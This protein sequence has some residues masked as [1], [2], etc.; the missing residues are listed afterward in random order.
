M[1]NTWILGPCG[2]DTPELY[3]QTGLHL[4][5]LMEDKYWFYKASFDKANRSSFDSKRCIGLKEGLKVFEEIKRLYSNIRLTTDVHEC[6]QVEQLAPLI[7]CIQIPAFLCRQTDL[8]IECAKHFN[9][10]NIKKMQ[11][12]GPKNIIKITNKI[13]QINSNCEVWITER[14]TAFGYEKLLVDFSIVSEL[15]KHFDCVILDCTHSTQKWESDHTGGNVELAKQYFI[16]SPLFGYGGVFAET[17]PNPLEAISDKETQ[18]PLNHMEE[19]IRKQA[20]TNIISG[21]GNSFGG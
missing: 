1:I 10:I 2:I 5:S 4:Y 19:L 18:I 20:L 15:K 21:Y 14:G 3:L 6:W 12:L 17:H 16:S 13:K 11:H 7:D 8:I 9:I